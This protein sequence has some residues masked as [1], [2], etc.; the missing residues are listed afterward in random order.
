[1]VVGI[2]VGESARE[3]IALVSISMPVQ[4]A[5]RLRKFFTSG[6]LR[7]FQPAQSIPADTQPDS[8]NPVVED[9]ASLPPDAESL[10]LF[11]MDLQQNAGKVFTRETLE[12]RA[13]RLSAEGNGLVTA[14]LAQGLI[15][16]QPDS[17]MYHLCEESVQSLLHPSTPTPAPVQ[18]APSEFERLRA[19]VLAARAH[20]DSVAANHN[21]YAQ[22]RTSHMKELQAARAL[23]EDAIAKVTHLEESLATAKAQAETQRRY[24][25][26]LEETLRSL[27]DAS[28]ALAVAETELRSAESAYAKL[29][30]L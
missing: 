5:D 25:L 18:D 12:S 17:S 1:M 26:R 4:S 2:V 13:A 22:Q 29:V 28:T 14:A 3:D 11:L 8:T 10:A 20:R 27:P 19:A 21:Q 16:Q 15:H 6:G 30:Q 7:M 23:R 9:S 24:I